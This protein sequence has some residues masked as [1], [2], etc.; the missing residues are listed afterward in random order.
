MKKSMRLVVSALICALCLGLFA[1]AP[2]LAQEDVPP[3]EISDYGDEMCDLF[4]SDPSG[5]LN[6][7][8]L[9]YVIRVALAQSLGG[10]D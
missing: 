9:R 2:A 3:Q 1:G 7:V 8:P 4:T 10:E 5:A 6:L